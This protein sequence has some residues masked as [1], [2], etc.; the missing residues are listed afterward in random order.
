MEVD[1]AKK[2]NE[3]LG[4]ILRKLN[5][6]EP[7]VKKL[8]VQPVDPKMAVFM[9]NLKDVCYITTKN[10]FGRKEI[11]LVTAKKTYFSNLSLKTIEQK[12]VSNPHFM[13]TSKYY[14]VNLDKV[15]GMKV[16][17][18]RDLWFTGIKKGIK[19]AVSDT[20]LAKFLER[21]G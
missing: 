16:S 9:L 11:G 18:A 3:L 14:I 21:L 19:N 12:L 13:R 5:F 6:I 2:D 8:P 20:Y 7:G 1:V 10:E 4:K 17:S 15:C